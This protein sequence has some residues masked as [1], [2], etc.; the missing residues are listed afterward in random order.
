MKI[1]GKRKNGFIVDISGDELSNL[2]G[3]YY[4]D[5]AAAEII[6]NK[7]Q[8]GT[9]IKVSSMYKQLYSLDHGKNELGGVAKTLR[10]M[11]D[12][13][14]VQNPVIYPDEKKEEE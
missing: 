3:F 2:I 4:H 8:Y 1:L 10:A 7:F 14:E 13:I 11:A 5:Q 12:L 6:E 9:E